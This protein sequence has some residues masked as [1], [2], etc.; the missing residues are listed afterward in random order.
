MAIETLFAQNPTV[1]NAV[2]DKIWVEEIVISAPELGG[3]AQARVRLRKFMTTESGA[4]FSPEPA[5]TIVVDSI[6]SGSESDS[7]LDA[8]VSSLMSYV[9]KK[10]VEAGVVATPSE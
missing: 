6:I 5:E 2:Y 10:G 9:A 3:D 4:E 7:D 1:I 8:A